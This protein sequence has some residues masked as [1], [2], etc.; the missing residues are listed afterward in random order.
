M[1]L[2]ILAKEACNSME[3]NE[4]KDKLLVDAKELTIIELLDVVDFGL[5]LKRAI[6][7]SVKQAKELSAK[8]QDLED[9]VSDR[10]NEVQAAQEQLEEL[11][12]AL[13]NFKSDFENEKTLRE[14]SIEKIENL[15]R[16]LKAN[17]YDIKEKDLTISQLNENLQ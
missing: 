3:D 4:E 11:N 2:I 9:I 15:E 17:E 6:D 7:I 5:W 13:S 10:T 12:D 16:Q 8:N 1:G 14:E